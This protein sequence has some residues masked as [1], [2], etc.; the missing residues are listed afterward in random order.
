MATKDWILPKAADTAIFRALPEGGVLFSTASEV[1]FGVNMVGAR[2]WELL[3]PATRTYE[4]LC[5]VLC[6]EYSDVGAEVIRAD[7]RRFLEQLLANGLVI[8]LPPEG[9]ASDAPRK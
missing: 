3:P 6:A 4:E 9:A 8:A 7:A 1:Y 2:I 5:K